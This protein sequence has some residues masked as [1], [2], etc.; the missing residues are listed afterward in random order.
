MLCDAD[1]KIIRLIRPRFFSVDSHR[2]RFHGG[3][4]RG[5]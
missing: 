2:S 3:S 1:I 5:E 4:G